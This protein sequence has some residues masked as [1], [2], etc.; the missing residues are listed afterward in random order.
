MV[1][2]ALLESMVNGSTVVTEP[3]TVA[4]ALMSENVVVIAETVSLAVVLAV[5][6]LSENVVVIAEAVVVCGAYKEMCGFNQFE[7][8]KEK[9]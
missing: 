4:V 5:A 3:V 2:G 7:L 6:M 8:L 1:N 9:R